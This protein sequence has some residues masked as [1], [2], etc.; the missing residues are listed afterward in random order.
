MDRV[1]RTHRNT[2]SVNSRVL[3]RS[4]APETIRLFVRLVGVLFDFSS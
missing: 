4:V 2:V 3:L 1:L